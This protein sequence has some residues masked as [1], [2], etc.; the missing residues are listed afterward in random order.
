MKQKLTLLI[1][2][3][4]TSLGVWATSPAEGAYPVEGK[5]YYLFANK[6]NSTDRYYLYWD[7]TNSALKRAAANTK[8]NTNYYK[9]TVTKVSE[10]VYNIT[11]IGTSTKLTWSANGLT[12]GAGTNLDL[13][14]EVA[15]IH[16]LRFPV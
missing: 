6:Y 10:G 12:L 9:W 13:S 11:N 7:N 15:Y 14:K 16:C 1:L 2:A 5:T 3:L 4:V 8:E